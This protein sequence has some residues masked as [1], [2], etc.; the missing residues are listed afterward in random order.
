[1]LKSRPA[2]AKYV[3]RRP[4]SLVSPFYRRWLAVTSCTDGYYDTGWEV[5]ALRRRGG[6]GG[7]VQGFVVTERANGRAAVPSGGL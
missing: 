6:R 3:M 2:G 1:M 7:G 5:G 4:S